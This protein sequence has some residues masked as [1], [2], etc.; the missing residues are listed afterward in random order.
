MYPNNV[1]PN[2]PQFKSLLVPAETL[3][4]ELPKV[5]PYIQE[6]PVQPETLPQYLS[7]CGMIRDHMINHAMLWRWFMF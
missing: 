3:C 5:S 6:R 1:H 2:L 7:N 4:N